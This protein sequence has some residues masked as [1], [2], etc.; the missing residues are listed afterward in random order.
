[1]MKKKSGLSRAEKTF[2]LPPRR[3]AMMN[4]EKKRGIF[5]G[6]NNFALTPPSH[7]L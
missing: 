7:K 1:M 5:K 2:P 3:K 4:D 6:K